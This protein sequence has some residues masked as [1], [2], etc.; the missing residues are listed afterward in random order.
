MG[1]GEEG[2][3]EGGREG[4]KGKG[5]LHTHIGVFT[6]RRLYLWTTAVIWFSSPSSIRFRY[7]YLLMNIVCLQSSHLWFWALFISS[8]YAQTE[9]ENKP[10]RCFCTIIKCI[11]HFPF[12]HKQCQKKRRRIG[13]KPGD[14]DAADSLEANT[15][16]SM[17]WCDMI[18]FDGKTEY[19]TMNFSEFQLHRCYA[20]E[21]EHWQ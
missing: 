13:K 11:Q 15:A 19:S 14:N 8:D 1:N 3:R 6:S 17:L 20:A 10:G 18:W 4:R 16:V 9:I 12:R 5:K 7:L 2:G 21:R